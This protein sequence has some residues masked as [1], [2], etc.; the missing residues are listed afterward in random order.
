MNAIVYP[1]SFA[2]TAALSPNDCARLERLTAK[3]RAELEAG[4]AYIGAINRRGVARRLKPQPLPAD[5]RAKVAAYCGELLA[6]K[7]GLRETQS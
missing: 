5:Y 2:A 6:R 7:A 4:R 1:Q 3:Q